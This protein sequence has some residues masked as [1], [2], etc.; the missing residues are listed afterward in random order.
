MSRA[1]P[2]LKQDYI[3]SEADALLIG[4]GEKFDPITK[5]PIPADDILNAY[6][7]V[8]LDFDDL[9]SVVHHK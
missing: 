4:Y 1:V 2:F 3:E 5:P 8:N 6:L 7:R 9:P